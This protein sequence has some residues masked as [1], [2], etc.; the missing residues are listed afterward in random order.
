[1]SLVLNDADAIARI[2]HHIDHKTTDTGAATWREPV[3]HY[4]SDARFEAELT[5]LRRLPVP[6]C[7]SAAL[8]AVGDYVAR[9][10]AGTP[11]LAVRGE[12]HQVRVFRNTCRH[13]GMPVAEGSGC[14]RAFVCPYHAWSYGLDGT[15]RHT[16]GRGGFPDVDKAAHGL[17]PVAGAIEQGGLV[18]V[19]Q[20]TALD[21]GAL[22]AVPDLLAPEQQVFDASAFSDPT[23]WKLA[24]ETSMEGYHIKA[25][26]NESF[27]PFGFDNLNVVETFGPNSR[28]IFPFR[29]IEK[30][31]DVPPAE[32]RLQG[33][34][35]DVF[36]LFPNTHISVLSHHTHLIILEPLAPDRTEY[37]FY[38]LSNRGDD[39]EASLER[40]KKDAAFLKDG[41]LTEDRE[42][43]NAIFRGLKT[44]GNSHLTFGR[45]EPAIVHFHQNMA[46]MMDKLAAA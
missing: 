13:R 45:F 21:P 39:P 3:D 9:Q 14:A 2:F 7:P 30:L 33:M 34:V 1:M 20:D 12:D 32:R 4:H 22:G 25:L 41:G 42:A 6:F 29:R 15:L 5:L 16:P 44:G 40:A 17:V 11:L 24:A 36:Q 31:R 19:T 8:P 27:Y 43:A 18:W 35:T 28:I 26:H 38:R 23:N 46:A 10:A 37:V